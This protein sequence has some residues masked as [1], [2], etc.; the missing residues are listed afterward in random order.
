MP[1]DFA[2]TFHDDDHLHQEREHQQAQDADRL[3]Q[4]AKLEPLSDGGLRTSKLLLEALSKAPHHHEAKVL[5]DRLYQLFVPRWHFPMLA[6]RV[7]NRAYAAAIAAKV[8]PGDVVLDIGC[9][10]G[11][12]AMLAA[13]AGAEHV[14]TCEQ[15]PLIAQ[16]AAR[17]IEENGLADRITVIP[18]LSRNL[19]VGVDLPEPADVVI[20]E[21]VDTML[22]G[23]G[24]LATLKHAMETLAKP[25]ARAIP[26]RGRLMARLVESDKLLNLWRPQEAEGFDL[27]AFHHFATVA[28]I[29]PND[30]AACGLRSL[31]PA[32]D[33]FGFDFTS[34]E[35]LA[36]RTTEQLDCSDAGTMHAVF[37]YF[38]LDL[39]P[40]IQVT[41]GLQSDGHWGRTAFLLNQPRSAEPGGTLTITAHH[42][43][44][45]LSVSVHAAV[46]CT[47]DAHQ[48]AILMEQV[49]VL[50]T[51]CDDTFLPSSTSH[52]AK[53]GNAPAKVVEF[54]I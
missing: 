46:D 35:I 25:D 54:Q 38:E 31:G 1:K 44:S 15:H 6:D 18:K 5:L 9:G 50:G 30:F 3:V 37:V 17:V 33:L 26:E 8:R 28:R 40:G 36:G 22:L 14:Y 21:I 43:T 45:E 41:N 32:K 52:Y 53:P 49:W 10:A 34:P 12:T 48:R 13:R 27:S 11:L 23:E 24:A 19:I 47:D 4:L 2:L 20:S 16:A 51:R 39:A 7:R 29:T 42:D